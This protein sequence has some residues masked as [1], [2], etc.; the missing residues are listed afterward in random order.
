MSWLVS[1]GLPDT[2]STYEP[3]SPLSIIGRLTRLELPDIGDDI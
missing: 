3:F 1:N 2:G